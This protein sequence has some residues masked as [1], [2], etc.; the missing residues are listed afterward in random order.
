MNEQ[1][2]IERADACK[3]FADLEKLIYD[4]ARG[5][6]SRTDCK[7]LVSKMRRLV[8]AESTTDRKAFMV[9]LMKVKQDFFA[10]IAR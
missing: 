6:A 7:A 1:D 9:E 10:V 2:F 3:R 8:R 4:C 5:R